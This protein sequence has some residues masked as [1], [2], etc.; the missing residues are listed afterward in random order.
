[1]RKRDATSVY[2]A[3]SF[4]FGLFSSIVFTLNLVYHVTRVG[5]N[6]LQLVL[7]GTTL[8][9]TVLVFEVP[10]GVVADVYSRR[11]S[12]IVGFFVIGVG[13]LIEGT[14][15]V[16]PAVLLAQVVWGF[17]WTFISGARSAWIADEVGQDKVASVYLRATQFQQL[18]TLLGI[19]IS[20]ALGSVR[21]NLPILIGGGL[22]IL[23]GTMLALIMPEE[24]FRPTPRQERETWSAM[25]QTLRDGLGLV[26]KR[27]VLLTFLAI[28]VFIGLSSE[29]YDRLWTAH[30]LENFRF[31][32]AGNLNNQT[33]FGIMRFG[34]MLLTLAAGMLPALITG[35]GASNTRVIGMQPALYY[36]PA[37]GVMW[38]ADWA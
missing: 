11:L 5:L 28:G 37:L 30:I 3:S 36:F 29:G 25:T 31:P 20:V 1:M 12:T 33:W 34:S 9:F 24:G 38:L 2:W 13:N 35:V 21:L 16:F 22:S 23:V 18:G 4:G 15:P 19:P 8:E 17:G 27:S 14:F 7:V 6:P 26:R 10:T 32:S